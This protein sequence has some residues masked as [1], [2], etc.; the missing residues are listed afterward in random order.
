[1]SR[2]DYNLEKPS[3]T[4]YLNSLDKIDGSNN[5]CRFNVIWDSFL[6]RDFSFYKVYF[7]FYS[8]G[9]NYKDATYSS[10]QYVF[11][12]AKINLNF[13]GRSFSYD[14]NTASNSINLGFIS[15]DLQLTTS[16]SN[17]LSCWHGQNSP[18]TL[19]RPCQNIISVSVIN[20]FNSTNSTT[21]YLTDTNSAGT[22]LSTDMTNWTL[23]LEFVPIGSSKI[24]SHGDNIIGN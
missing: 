20:T 3:Y 6:P 14:S 13:Q 9:G 16:S 24:T 4:L 7:S 22:S 18:K 17:T 1:M 2:V 21:V 23:I 12:S 8:V 5:N 15:R 11:S 19:A 10:T